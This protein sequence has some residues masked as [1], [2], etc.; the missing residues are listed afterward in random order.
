MKLLDSTVRVASS[1]K[2]PPPLYAVQASKV[3][4]V[5]VTSALLVAKTQ[6][7]YPPDEVGTDPFLSVSPENV[8][9]VPLLR[10]S[11]SCLLPWPLRAAELMLIM[12]LVTPEMEMVEVM[13]MSVSTTQMLPSMAAQEER[14]EKELTVV[15]RPRRRKLGGLDPPKDC[16]VLSELSKMDGWLSGR[17][18]GAGWANT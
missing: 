5:K 12:V 11:K 6:S 9:W 13:S 18:G 3:L 16:S 4:L 2:T 14:S 8:T 17:R 15:L 7:P 10:M 1:V